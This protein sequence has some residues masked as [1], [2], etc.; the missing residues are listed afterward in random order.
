MSVPSWLS[1]TSTSTSTPPAH[2][3]FNLFCKTISVILKY[4]NLSV[5]SL[6]AQPCYIYLNPRSALSRRTYLRAPPCPRAPVCPNRSPAPPSLGSPAM[7]CRGRSKSK[8]S[9]GTWSASASVSSILHHDTKTKSNLFFLT[10]SAAFTAIVEPPTATYSRNST[11]RREHR[12]NSYP[13][14]SS[15]LL[16]DL[17]H[18][19]ANR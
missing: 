11:L 10:I 18:S 9:S 3:S 16:Q 7:L 5:F 4:Q 12:K 2:F 13:T 14:T 15:L 8:I 1:P 6:Q 19:V 17:P